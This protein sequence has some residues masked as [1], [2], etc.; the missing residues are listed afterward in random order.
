MTL[1]ISWFYIFP[2][3]KMFCENSPILYFPS[4]FFLTINPAPTTIHTLILK[5]YTKKKAVKQHI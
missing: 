1:F 2:E 3:V 4:I 5:L